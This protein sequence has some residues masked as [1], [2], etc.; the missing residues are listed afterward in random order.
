MPERRGQ[1]ASAADLALRQAGASPER[2]GSGAA[3]TRRRAKLPGAIRP[4][5]PLLMILPSLL[6]TGVIIGFP[7][8]ILG[9]TSLHRVSRFGQV[10]D[11][12]GIGN[13]LDILAD[14]LFISSLERTLVWT[15]AV[16][17]G[18]VLL[19]IPIALMLNEEF[20][21]RTLARVIILLPWSVSLT[22]TAIVW[23]WALAG[24]S[25]MVN[26]SLMDLGLMQEAVE[27]LGTAPAAFTIEIIV[28]II[29]SIPFSTALLLGGLSSIPTS[30]YEAA[31]M[32]GAG[33]WACF[34]F[35]TLPML[36]PFLNIAIVLNV[37]YV[38][39]SFP[40]IWVMTEGGPA[41]GTDI[42]VT[43]LYKLAFRFGQLGKASVISLMMFIVLM[44]F[45]GAYVAL[46]MRKPEEVT[47]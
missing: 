6:L 7:I 34:R 25:G 21:G 38:F 41:N 15:L 32:D 20:F 46:L 3:P 16:T 30:L 8:I 5:P 33:G 47:T 23:R 2:N 10:L 18:T 39:N 45:V 29:V 24:R 22:M 11:L 14:P 9:W 1:S 27:W 40:I 37:I 17:L 28:G 43:Y 12:N 4:T 26:A 35:V 31:I 42:L 13:Y 36:R 44:A 19:A